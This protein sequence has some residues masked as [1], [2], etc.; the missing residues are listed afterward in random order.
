MSNQILSIIFMC[1]V[2]TVQG[3]A[4][5]QMLE[6]NNQ[7]TTRVQNYILDI[8]CRDSFDSKCNRRQWQQDSI[9]K[10]YNSLGMCH[11]S[12]LFFLYRTHM[13]KDIGSCTVIYRN[14]SC[15]AG[16]Y[17]IHTDGRC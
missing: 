7:K 3:L 11:Y 17:D 16:L 13:E 15:R 2:G 9:I 10:K 12:N 8:A 6:V 14:D 1:S 4:L 5:E